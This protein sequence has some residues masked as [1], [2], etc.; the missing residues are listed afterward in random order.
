V[1]TNYNA[2][3]G[4]KD[5]KGPSLLYGNIIPVLIVDMAETHDKLQVE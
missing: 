5:L 1:P 3:G 2:G 4:V